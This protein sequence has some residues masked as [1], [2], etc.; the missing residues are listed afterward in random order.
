MA[1]SA[2]V[3]MVYWNADGG[4]SDLCLNGSRCAAMLA[5]EAGWASDELTL[6]TDAGVLMARRL[7]D[8][9]IEID[10]PPIVET[11]VVRTLLVA[12]EEP[13]TGWYI[14]VGVPHFVV[15]CPTS[16][17]EAPVSR[18]GPPLRRHADLGVAGANV[19]FV[20]FG[21]PHDLEIR[22]FE[23]GVEAETLACGTG[24]VAAV[25]TGLAAGQVSLPVVAQTAGGFRLSVSGTAT[26]SDASSAQPVGAAFSLA[27]DAR[28]LARC[29]LLAASES[30]PSGISWRA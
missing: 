3:R 30:V 27:G 20:R 26:P 23:R 11:A 6:E 15:S 8:Q 29:D 24:V 28:V 18:L 21:G 1:E 16:M 4:R 2:G 13:V 25:A 9:S 7:D 10:L 22:S 5:L 17:A 19:H 14:N 12:G